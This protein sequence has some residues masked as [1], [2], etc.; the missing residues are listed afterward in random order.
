VKQ[1]EVVAHAE[2]GWASRGTNVPGWIGMGGVSFAHTES[3]G[4]SRDTNVPG[5]IRVGEVSFAHTESGGVSRDTNVPGW[6]RVG[7][8]MVDA[9]NGYPPE[10]VR[11][12]R[13][14]LDYI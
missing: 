1:I 7:E 4:V 9:G 5:W 2:S 11:R 6:I 14:G 3:G 12:Q 10:L 8:V 13:G